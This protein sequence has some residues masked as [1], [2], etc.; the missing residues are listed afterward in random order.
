MRPGL[1]A[2]LR[3]DLL[4]LEV[5]EPQFREYSHEPARER[6]GPRLRAVSTEQR[7]PGLTAHHLDRAQGAVQECERLAQVEVPFVYAYRKV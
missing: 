5:D 2:T 3:A 1:S 6:R 4:A 7:L